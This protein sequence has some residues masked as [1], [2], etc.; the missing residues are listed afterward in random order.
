MCIKVVR[1]VGDYDTFFDINLYYSNLDTL[2]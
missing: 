1:F 2:E